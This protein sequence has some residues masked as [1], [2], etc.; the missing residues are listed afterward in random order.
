MDSEG[1]RQIKKHRVE[2][3]EI[4]PI[5]N[6]VEYSH[7]VLEDR[8]DV[9]IY[10]K[11]GRCIGVE[12]TKCVSS[13]IANDKLNMLAVKSN[14]KLAIEQYK[15]E[16][17][18][19]QDYINMEFV[20]A[21]DIGTAGVNFKRDQFIRK[22]IEELEAHRQGLESYPYQL[23][24]RVKCS[25]SAIEQSIIMDFTIVFCGRIKQ[26]DVEHAITEKEHKLSKY[27]K[28]DKNKDINE[29]WLVIN[30]PYEENKD[31]E[32][33]NHSGDIVSEYDRIY[34]TKWDEYKRLK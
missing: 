23:V 18:K 6:D 20:L 31:I 22:F 7:I 12:T 11:D 3:A 33:Y 34:L 29:Y 21:D 24:D 14:V 30:S 5:F 9:K 25:K 28:L 10:A 8:P 15:Y 32:T 4:G 13:D 17:E 19:K 16:T 2:L 27:I 1:I 26:S